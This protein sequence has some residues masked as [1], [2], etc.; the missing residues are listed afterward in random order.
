MERHEQKTIVRAK[1]SLPPGFVVIREGRVRPD[2]LVYSA[3]SGDWLRADSAEW[4]HPTPEDVAVCCVVARSAHFAEPGFSDA[5]RRT[6]TIPA[7]AGSIT[8]E[9]A[10]RSS[11]RQ[12]SLY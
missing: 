11:I 4:L 7:A 12:P 10:S 1:E 8:P 9:P 3:P 6:Y 2:D 5:R